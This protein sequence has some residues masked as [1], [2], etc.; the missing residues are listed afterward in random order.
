MNG[1]PVESTPKFL[2][3]A[4]HYKD[5]YF[6]LVSI[7][8][9]ELNLSLPLKNA[10]PQDLLE[11]TYQGCTQGFCYPPEPNNSKLATSHPTPQL[12]I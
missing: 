4:E 9:H 6:G 10:Q 3:Q 8:K 5:P 11:V 12:P 7:F 2:S 1:K